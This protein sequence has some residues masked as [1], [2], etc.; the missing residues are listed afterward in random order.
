ML[1]T[2]FER[3]LLASSSNRR[4]Y[5]INTRVDVAPSSNAGVRKFF[6]FIV[7]F[8]RGAQSLDEPDQFVLVLELY[9]YLVLVPDLLNLHISI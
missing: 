7:L 4:T 5:A 9:L 2:V 8:S 3:E 6:H 1:L